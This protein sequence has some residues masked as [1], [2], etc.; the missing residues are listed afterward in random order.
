M[1]CDTSIPVSLLKEAAVLD[2]RFE[3]NPRSGQVEFLAPRGSPRPK[4]LVQQLR[5]HRQTILLAVRA[6]N[7]WT[8]AASALLAN[9]ENLEDRAELRYL[10]EERAGIVE[11]EAGLSRLEAERLAFLDLVQQFHRKQPQ[12]ARE[13]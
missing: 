1:S 5:Q 3:V 11:F 13:S 4:H 7:L 12:A 2:L 9:I 10:F 6:C 8:R